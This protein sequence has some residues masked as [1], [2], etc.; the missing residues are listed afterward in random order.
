M[1]QVGDDYG[2]IQKPF[3]EQEILGQIEFIEFDESADE[4][5]SF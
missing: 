1:E 2:Y 5:D 4:W 3:N